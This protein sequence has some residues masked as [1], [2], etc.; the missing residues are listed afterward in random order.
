MSELSALADKAK[1]S[2]PEIRS[3]G[4]RSA[5]DW[6]DPV[7]FLGE[8]QERGFDEFIFRAGEAKTHV[9][10]LETGIVF[11]CAHPQGSPIDILCPGDYLGLGFLKQ[12]IHSARVVL[13]SRVRAIPIEML[14]QLIAC[15]PDIKS[16][17]DRATEREFNAR[18]TEIVSSVPDSA[19]SRVAGFLVALSH[20]NAREGRD[21]LIVDDTLSSGVV[22]EWLSIDLDTLASQLV[23]LRRRGLVEHREPE[24]LFLA[25]I[26]GLET[27]YLQSTGAVPS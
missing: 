23:E 1:S 7:K 22:A 24:G 16:H 10:R 26:P 13:R 6:I 2:Q 15:D 20:L 17:L 25:D 27:V 9:Y 3:S 21:P 11:L 19:L 18:R 12:H 14:P 8:V 4:N 5:S